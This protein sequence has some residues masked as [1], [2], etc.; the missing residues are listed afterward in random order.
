[1]GR[2]WLKGIE[3]V[4]EFIVCTV[5]DT[6]KNNFKVDTATLISDREALGLK[7]QFKSK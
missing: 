6:S 2:V 5:T 4:D 1:M 3:S 7:W